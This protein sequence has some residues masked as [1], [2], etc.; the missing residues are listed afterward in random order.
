MTRRDCS[1]RNVRGFT[2][3][4]L[5][6]VVAIIGILAAVALPAYQDYTLKAKFSE[7][8][9]IGP[10]GQQAVAEYFGR[11]GRLPAD[12]DA[13]GLA[14]PGEYQGRAV[15]SLTVDGGLVVVGLRDVEGGQP[16]GNVHLR[17]SI[18]KVGSANFLI[19]N[20]G[21]IQAV[22]GFEPQGPPPQRAVVDKYMPGSCK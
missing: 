19:W 5:M 16:Y 18:P 13:A 2:L 3:I 7:A 12:N 9:V 22:D 14:A 11:W 8:F 20:C 21:G 15:S 10:V 1:S 4:E 6:F 17:P